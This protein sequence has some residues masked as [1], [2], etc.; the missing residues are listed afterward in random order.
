MQLSEFQSRFKDLM[1]DHPDAL[2]TPDEDLAAFCKSGDI[3]LSSRLK[4]YRNN[5]VG[6][7]SDV[8]IA[9]FPTIEKLVG[10]GF[11]EGMARSFILE[12]PPSEGC[13]TLYGAG[14]DK[15]IEGFELAKGLPY[16]PDMAR[17]ELALNTSY[18]AADDN[19]LTA[20]ALSQIAPEDLGDIEL[21]PR[22]SVY[23]IR[24]RFPITAI[25]AYCENPDES[26]G[27]RIDQ[28][29]ENVMVLRPEFE[30]MSVVL[31]DDETYILE[32]LQAGDRLGEAVENTLS[33]YQDFDFQS[34]LQKH[35]SLETFR[36]F[37]AK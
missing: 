11:L 14:F 18:Y 20:K 3:P 26:E 13:I 27:L 21:K 10:L 35:L 29:G 22:A 9:T 6:S 28:G 16:L 32:R 36:K 8:M 25:Q 30:T 34:F 33:T 17:Y 19:A 5:I 12:H 31:N 15:F 37:H 7:L 2:D 23:I 4:V 24:S 1:L